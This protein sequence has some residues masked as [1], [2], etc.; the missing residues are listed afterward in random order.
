MFKLQ[1]GIQISFSLNS[2]IIELSFESNS[3]S[4]FKN[5]PNLS[6][7]LIWFESMSNLY[8]E[9]IKNFYFDF[10]TSFGIKSVQIGKY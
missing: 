9:K 7:N 4:I 6:S 2:K 5:I 10:Q 8:F 3:N 1:N